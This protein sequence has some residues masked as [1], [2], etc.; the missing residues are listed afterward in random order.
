M[1]SMIFN[2]GPWAEATKSQPTYAKFAAAWED[3]EARKKEGNNESNVPAN[4][5]K[6]FTAITKPALRS[7]ILRMLHPDPE[8][9]ISIQEAVNEGWVKLI[10]CCAFDGD[11]EQTV[12]E[13]DAS[14]KCGKAAKKTIAK[15]HHHI[16]PEKHWVPQHRFDMGDGW[17]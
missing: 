3:L 6:M 9:R 17:Y 1:L 14:K 15:S 11:D 4:T 13:I 5:G 7:L 12:T 10:D 2:G 8:K 16:P